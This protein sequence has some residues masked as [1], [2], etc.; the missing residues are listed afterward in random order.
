MYECS[1]AKVTSTLEEN[2]LNTTTCSDL[3][4]ATY[5]KKMHK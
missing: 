2:F 5:C 4:I 3:A 1:Q